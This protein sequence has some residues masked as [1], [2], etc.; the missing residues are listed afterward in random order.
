MLAV[1]ATIILAVAIPNLIRVRPTSAADP[2]VNNLRQIDVMK[3]EWALE[4]GKTTSDVPTLDDLRPYLRPEWSN[5]L[6][7]CPEGGIYTIG[8]VGKKPTCSIGGSRH[9]LP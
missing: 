2:C 6:P 4:K 7:P 9:S 5:S 3:E 1:I 8:R